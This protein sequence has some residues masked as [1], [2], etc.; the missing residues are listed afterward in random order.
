MI[1]VPLAA[2]FLAYAAINAL[3]LFYYQRYLKAIRTERLALRGL[4]DQIE[5]QLQ[6]FIL[7]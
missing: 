5:A 6:R 2:F 3:Q 4:H 7:N 1:W